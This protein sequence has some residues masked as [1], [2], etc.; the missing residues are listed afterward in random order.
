MKI[1]NLTVAAALVIALVGCSKKRVDA[2]AE[3]QE[4]FREAQPEV[5]QEVQK[6]AADLQSGKYAEAV[7]AMNRA[8]WV[9]QQQQLQ[10]R[11]AAAL[12]EQQKRAA[13]AVILQTRQALQQ[14]PNLNSPQLHKA[15]SDLILR[16]HGEN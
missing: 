14:N 3:L 13:E 6:V 7:A 12:S 10:A 16:T 4:G 5:Q 15:M 8:L 2:S 11:Q 1:P 9:Q